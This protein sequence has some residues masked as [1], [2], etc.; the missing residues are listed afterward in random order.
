VLLWDVLIS[1]EAASLSQQQGNGAEAS[2]IKEEIY[3]YND[4]KRTG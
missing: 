1:D 2:D 3:Q 4:Y